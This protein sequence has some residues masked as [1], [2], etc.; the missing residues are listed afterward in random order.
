MWSGVHTATS[1]HVI[2][3]AIPAL[4]TDADGFLSALAE[5]GRAYSEIS[6]TSLPRLYD[7]IP[8]D[9]TYFLAFAPSRTL[10]MARSAR[11]PLDTDGFSKFASEF[12]DGL[13]ILHDHGIIHGALSAAT[14]GIAGDGSAAILDTPLYSTLRSLSLPLPESVHLHDPVPSYSIRG[15]CESACL[16]LEEVASHSALPAALIRSITANMHNLLAQKKSA[17][18]VEIRGTILEDIQEYQDQNHR[19]VQIPSSP[20]MNIESLSPPHPSSNATQGKGHPVRTAV[21]GLL[22]I[23]VLIALFGALWLFVLRPALNSGKLTLTS[24]IHVSVTPSSGKCSTAFTATGT[25]STKGTGTLTYHWIDTLNTTPTESTSSPELH[26][27]IAPQ[28][29]SFKVLHSWTVDS[30]SSLTGSIAL[31]ISTPTSRTV[32][33]P[34]HLACTS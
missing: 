15:D 32:S 29:R 30:K 27:H 18:A 13:Q 26:L 3:E 11:H 31:V 6:H 2:L 28:D 16:L 20:P 23:I 22:I 7:V 9:G 19:P 33:V 10:P 25:G 1:T 4:Y 14:V 21:T 8:L 34:V 5:H 24:A 17:G 12:L